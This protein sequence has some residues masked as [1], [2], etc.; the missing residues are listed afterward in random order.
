M[1]VTEQQ[2]SFWDTHRAKWAKPTEPIPLG[3]KQPEMEVS[4]TSS[5]PIDHFFKDAVLTLRDAEHWLERWYGA[6]LYG[7][8]FKRRDTDWLVIVKVRFRGRERVA[9]T[10]A[11][12]FAEAIIAL[13]KG[14]SNADLRWKNDQYPG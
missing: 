10:S 4:F 2:L 6:D 1:D 14:I 3:D 8:K 7:V 12:S 13:G 9:F 5:V 11:H